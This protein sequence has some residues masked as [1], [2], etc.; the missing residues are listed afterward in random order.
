MV[1]LG[2]LLGAAFA[3]ALTATSANAVAID[4]GV[5]APGDGYFFNQ[6]VTPGASIEYDFTFTLPSEVTTSS[7]VTVQ[8][9]NP[10]PGFNIGIADLVITWVSGFSTQNGPI[11]ITDGS[12][13]TIASA[14]LSAVLNGATATL[15]LTGT[16]L[17]GSAPGFD[18][19]F[20]LSVL[21]SCDAGGGCAPGDAPLPGAVVLFGS[22]LAGGVGGLQIMRRRRRVTAA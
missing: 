17:P 11:A 5:L 9:P 10:T 12:G 1:R 6:V 16:A 20:D 4:A 19:Q 15:H 3:V 18:P 7:S 2:G 8:L 14:V 22:V 13:L 21:A